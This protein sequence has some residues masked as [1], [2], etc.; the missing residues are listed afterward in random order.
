MQN[1]RRQNDD[2]DHDDGGDRRFILK[3]NGITTKT[4][5]DSRKADKVLGAAED[6]ANTTIQDQIRDLR[7]DIRRVHPEGIVGNMLFWWLWPIKFVADPIFAAA[8]TVA[9]VIDKVPL[10]GTVAS[11]GCQVVQW[12]AHTAYGVLASEKMGH[13]L[14][15]DA[16]DSCPKMMNYKALSHYLGLMYQASSD[17]AFRYNMLRKVHETAGRAVFLVGANQS[18]SSSLIA[19]PQETLTMVWEAYGALHNYADILEEATEMGELTSYVL[20][21]TI[22]PY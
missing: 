7:L 12:T 2:N 3:M 4:N 14:S 9:P 13:L 5:G 1:D 6:D 18:M 22:F 8:E 16:A 17:D 21:Q 11:T 15:S 20:V 10:V 19:H